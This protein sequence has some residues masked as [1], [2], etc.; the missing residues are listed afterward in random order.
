MTHPDE[1]LSYVIA[2]EFWNDS[3]A[4]NPPDEFVDLHVIIDGFQFDFPVDI[5]GASDFI[6]GFVR[7]GAMIATFPERV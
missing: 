1:S 3:R 7:A 2:I 6:L 4:S 5:C